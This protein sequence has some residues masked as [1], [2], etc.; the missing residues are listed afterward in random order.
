M[1]STLAAGL[2]HTARITIDRDR[3]IGFMGEELRVYSTPRMVLDVEMTSRELLLSHLDEGE[4]SV[5]TRVEIDHIAAAL[6][7][8]GVDVTSTIKEVD[9]RRVVFEFTVRDAVEEIGKGLHTR[10][11]VETTKTR[12]RLLAKAAKLK[13][14]G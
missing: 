13:A 4:D 11:V 2:K 5:G 10:F 12:E 6:N 14:A 1:K 3:T 9:R 7:G 8:S